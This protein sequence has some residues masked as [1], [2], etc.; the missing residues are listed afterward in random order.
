VDLSSE[1]KLWQ[2]TGIVIRMGYISIKLERGTVRSCVPVPSVLDRIVLVRQSYSSFWRMHRALICMTSILSG[3]FFI[4]AFLCRC[5]SSDAV[6]NWI[7]Y[8]SQVRGFSQ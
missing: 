6:G 1:H 4:M 5:V 2:G 8:R 3:K 7:P